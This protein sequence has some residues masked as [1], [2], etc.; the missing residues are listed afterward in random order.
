MKIGI[1]TSGGDAPG[2]NTCVARLTT[3]LTRKK[4]KVFGFIGGYRGLINADFIPLNQEA[5]TNIGYIG[6]SFLKS[7]RCPEF[8]TEEGVKKG[9][10]VLK[11]NKFDVLIAIG[12]DGTLRG[13]RDII[14]GGANCIF[15]PATIDNDIMISEKA[16]GFDTA[17]NNAVSAIDMIE[18]TMTAMDRGVVIETM[19]RDCSDIAVSCGLAVGASMI[20]TPESDLNFES[21]AKKTLQ[22]MKSGDT[23]PIII[24]QEHTLDIKALGEFLQEKTNIEFRAINLGY[25]QRGGAPTVGDRILAIKFAKCVVDSIEKGELNRC[26]SILNDDACVLPMKVI[27]KNAHKSS[28][29]LVD[30]VD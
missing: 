5:V 29:H 28:Q 18:Q 8:K 14:D 12:G 10:A 27:T 22:K 25:I 16:L 19:G 23:T 26:A 24:V 15:I 4:H 17:V 3:S 20:L 11:K 2:M 13:V 6:G 7:G 9:L 1:L 21:I 30:F